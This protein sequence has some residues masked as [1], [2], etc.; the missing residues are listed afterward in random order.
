MITQQDLK[1]LVTAAA[2]TGYHVN[3]KDLVLLKWD[4]GIQSHIP[5]PLPKGFS[6]VYFFKWKDEFL[7]VGK[8]GLNTKPRYLSQHYYIYENGSTLS[9]SLS[10]DSKF[11]ALIGDATPGE[12]L[13]INTTRFNILIPDTLSKNFVN[14]AEAFFILKC[15]PRFEGKQS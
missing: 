13:K 5:Q 10:N 12:W 14:F 2:N 9:K 8:A 7:K 11:S 6:A 3:I 4:A 1:L 15:N